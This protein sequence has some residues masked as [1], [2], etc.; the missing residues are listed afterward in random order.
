M[1]I[2]VADYNNDALPDLDRL[3]ML[4]EGNHAQKNAHGYRWL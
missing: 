4:P 3:D 1:G 2:D